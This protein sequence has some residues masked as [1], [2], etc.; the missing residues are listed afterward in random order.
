MKQIKRMTALL[1]TAVLLILTPVSALA[2]SQ[3]YVPTK[4]EFYEL[5]GGTWVLQSEE[6]YSYTKNGRIKSVTYKQTSGG[7]AYT[8]RYTWKGNYLKKQD[9]DYSSTTYNYKH[10]KLKSLVHYYKSSNKTSTFT[11]SWKKRNGTVYAENGAGGSIVVNKRNQMTKLTS[12]TSS[13]TRTE[14]FKYFSNGNMKT[15][16][17]FDSD[18]TESFRFHRK[19]YPLSYTSSN[20]Y[21]ETYSYKKKKGKITEELITE[22]NSSGAVYYYKK[23]FK[24]HK[25]ISRSVR[26]CD[27]FGFLVMTPYMWD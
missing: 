26:N 27:A 18:S 15:E 23:V 13:G 1:I 24:K 10:K 9:D 3:E 11:V 14:S 17:F 20:G 8:Y 6:T 7:S 25:K 21:Q 12:N 2:A 4:A 22:K 16:T 5:I 19:G